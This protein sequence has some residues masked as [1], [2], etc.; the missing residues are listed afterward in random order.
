MLKAFELWWCWWWWVCM[1]AHTLAEGEGTDC[2]EDPHSYCGKEDRAKASWITEQ[3][4]LESSSQ[5]LETYESGWHDPWKLYID[6]DYLFLENLF[7]PFLTTSTL[8]VDPGFQV[9]ESTCS[10]LILRK[11]FL[12]LQCR[13]HW[14]TSPYLGQVATSRGRPS[15]YDQLWKRK[16]V[17]PGP[18]QSCWPWLSSP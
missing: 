11:L 15:R 4:P 9:Q 3:I 7:Y 10:R 5:A 18:S 8:K 17:G 2:I 12:V 6:P 13:G 1:H 14:Q 16:G